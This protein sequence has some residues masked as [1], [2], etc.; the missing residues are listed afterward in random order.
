MKKTPLIKNALALVFEA[1][2]FYALNIESVPLSVA[3][4]F[5]ILMCDGGVIIPSVALVAAS[6]RYKNIVMTANALITVT[7]T[8][9]LW[10][11]Y[12]KKEKKAG[13]ESI[14][15]IFVSQAVYIAFYEGEILNK[16]V[17]TAI[18]TIF[19]FVFSVA[20]NT[21]RYKNL[22]AKPEYGESLSIAAAFTVVSVFGMDIVGENAFRALAVFI[23]LF[24]V[25]LFKSPSALAVALFVALPLSIHTGDLGYFAL[26]S[27]YFFAAYPF[28]NRYAV[29]SALFL[30][31]VDVAFAYLLKFYAVYGYIEA[32]FTFVP[33]FIFSL[34]PSFVYERITERGYLG[35]D[36]SAQNTVAGIKSRLSG[37]IYDLSEAFAEMECALGVLS[38]QT[39][40][41]RMIIKNVS[42]AAAEKA[43]TECANYGIC[44]LADNNSCGKLVELGL[45]KGRLSFID[46]PKEYADGCIN[47]NPLIYEI[48]RLIEGYVERS[49]QLKKTEVIKKILS[50][51]AHGIRSRL[52]EVAFD[53]TGSIKEDAKKEREL[54]EFLFKRGLKTYGVTVC[55]ESD[56]IYSLIVDENADNEVIRRFLDQFRG[57]TTELF[58]A[59]K[60]RNGLK[61]LEFSIAP[62][63]Q[64]T[65]GVSAVT[66]TGS[67]VSGDVHSLVKLAKNRFLV[68]LS[69]GMG[70]GENAVS[71]SAAAIGLTEGMLKAGL[72]P[73]V[74]LPIVNE[75]I[76]VTTEDNFSAM[77]IGIVD[78]TEKTCDF[79]KIGAPYGFI[80][81][82]D[83]IRFI[84]GSSLPIGILDELKP[85]TAHA[86]TAE[87]DVI[88]MLSDG[89]T[90]AFGSSTDFI[91]FLKGAPTLNPQTLADRVIQEAVARTRGIADDDMTCLCVRLIRRAA[92]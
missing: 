51:S 28:R 71:T 64:A 46:L 37:E 88:M 63:L 90:D 54:T 3:P 8:V 70:S 69:D 27:A 60:I 59:Q 48:N 89:V 12:R 35:S 45:S 1:A 39:E 67:P 80:L 41:R 38:E 65:F 74:V 21:V 47:P 53:L 32:L 29:F 56:E 13:V 7:A 79:I 91:E 31:A 92:E 82:D 33:A 24:S 23:I 44:K 26:C 55:G 9:L 6:L 50:L 72:R 11:I 68:A 73:N 10:A 43:C 14:F 83:G 20:V 22:T 52:S 30:F 66:K 57:K 75:L 42:R 81:S 84:E 58:S 87:G 77:D 2:V 85:T 76:S 36:K 5:A 49:E 4:Y 62:E 34:I 18:I 86:G 61:F 16:L 25:R 40:K 19:Y 15:F 78:L 17:Y